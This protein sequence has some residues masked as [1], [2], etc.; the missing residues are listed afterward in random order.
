MCYQLVSEEFLRNYWKKVL[1]DSILLC[2]PGCPQ[3]LTQVFLSP[4]PP[5]SWDN[6]YTPQPVKTTE[7]YYFL[8]F[9]FLFCFVLRQSR[10]PPTSASRVAEMTDTCHHAPMSVFLVEMGF[11]YV[12]QAGLELL[13]S[14]GPPASASQSAGITGMSHHARLSTL[15]L[16]LSLG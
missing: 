5:S 9:S 7:M 14:N 11:H 13:T 10:Y 4:H 15:F 2:C 1:R 3:I 8:F 12:G 6:R 16:T